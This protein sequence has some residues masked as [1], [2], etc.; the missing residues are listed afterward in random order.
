MPVVSD[1]INATGI[2]ADRKF[3]PSVG[4]WSDE[5]T[6][7]YIKCYNLNKQGIRTKHQVIFEDAGKV[8][9]DTGVLIETKRKEKG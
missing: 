3:C 7:S 9:V 5:P 4:G 1:D 8:I 2:N 6:S